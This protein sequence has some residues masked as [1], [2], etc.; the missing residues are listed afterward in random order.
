[1]R[2]DIR[3]S[4]ARA[5]TLPRFVPSAPA[6]TSRSRAEA[7]SGGLTAP[8]EHSTTRI[9]EG[10]D[11]RGAAAAG[12]RRGDAAPRLRDRPGDRATRHAGMD[13]DRL[14]LDLLRARQASKAGARHGEEA[15]PG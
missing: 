9:Y 4:G 5:V 8:G 2:S 7:L 13:A 1:M 14:F 3:V 10:P 15:G 12:A 6:P 11:R